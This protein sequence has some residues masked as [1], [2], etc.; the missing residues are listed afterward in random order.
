MALSIRFVEPAEPDLRHLELSGE[1][2][3]AG[4]DQGG[5]RGGVLT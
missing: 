3:V 1:L 4:P 5:E 2:V